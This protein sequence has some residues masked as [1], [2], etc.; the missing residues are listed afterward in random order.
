MCVHWGVMH[1]HHSL[2][3]PPPRMVKARSSSLSEWGGGNVMA[4]PAGT[5][6]HI[7]RVLSNCQSV[8]FDPNAHNTQC[9]YSMCV[10]WG[11]CCVYMYFCGSH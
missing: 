9:V 11:V 8:H 4:A 2:G 10:V 3:P 7:L 5:N 1:R 6:I